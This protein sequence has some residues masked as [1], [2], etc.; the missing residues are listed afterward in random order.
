MSTA[1]ACTIALAGDDDQLG[2]VQERVEDRRVGSGQQLHACL[3]HRLALVSEQLA[4]C[5]RHWNTD[6]GWLNTSSEENH[7]AS[8]LPLAVPQ[9]AVRSVLLQVEAAKAEEHNKSNA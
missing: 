3:A 2:V 5:N 9:D 7:T 6:R 1:M 8:P 4:V